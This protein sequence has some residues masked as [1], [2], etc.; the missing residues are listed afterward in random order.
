[1]PPK[2]AVFFGTRPEAI[3]LAPV[4]RRLDADRRLDLLSVSTGQ[5][6]EMLDQVI[7]IFDLPV[8]HDLDLMVPSQTLAG[9]SARLLTKVDALLESESPDFAVVQGDTTTVLM[10]ALACFYRRIP[11]GHVEAGLRT[12]NVHSPF[13]E[14]ANRILASPISTLHFAPTATSRAN[15]LDDHIDASRVV[16]TGN[17]VIDA[18]QIEV[19]AQQEPAARD[20]IDQTLDALLPSRWRTSEYVLVT[21]HRRENFGGGFDQICDAL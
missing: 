17:T 13:P 5:H 3:K 4:I 16:V 12:R 2:V 18:L 21:G 19:A 9:L 8:H 15:L 20:V 11:I 1:M 10:A 14:E 7:Q 6:R